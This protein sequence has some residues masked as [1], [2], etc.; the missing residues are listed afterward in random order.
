MVFTG[1]LRVLNAHLEYEE[2]E[3]FRAVG[4]KDCVNPLHD[5]KSAHIIDDI[6]HANPHG[7]PGN[8]HGPDEQSRL[9]FLIGKDV[10][11]AGLDVSLFSSGP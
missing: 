2:Y 10:L 8:S 4:R 9:R 5:E 1:Y 11:N 6:G 7:G 3:K